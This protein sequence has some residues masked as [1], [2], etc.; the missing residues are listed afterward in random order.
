[1]RTITSRELKQNP[2][3]VYRRVLASGEE[4]VITSH[5]ASVGVKL[6]PD[7]PGPRRWVPAAALR[8]AVPRLP[9]E[10]VDDLLRDLDALRDAEP[11][12]DPWDDAE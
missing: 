5:G 7:H 9:R 12:H 11:L 10:N 4:H 6:V 8:A 1:M 2:G 3:E